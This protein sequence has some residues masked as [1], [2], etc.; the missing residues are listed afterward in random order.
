MTMTNAADPVEVCP[1]CEGAM[2][3]LGAE[4]VFVDRCEECMG[5]WLDKGERAKVIASKSAIRGLDIGSVATG[6]KQ[7][8]IVDID[9]P[10]CGIPMRHVHH[11]DQRHIGYEHC[12][13][14][15]GSFFDAGELQD[16]SQ[17]TLSDI[18]R[19]FFRF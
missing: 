13:N 19:N 11:P 2:R 5:I 17:L 14:C 16:L 18:V 6:K 3:R 10:R 12:E 4:D 15:G 7:D 9:C 1:K 8:K